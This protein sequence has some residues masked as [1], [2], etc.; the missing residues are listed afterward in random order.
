MK[1][2]IIGVIVIVVLAAAGS[3][4]L[5]GMKMEQQF[6]DQVAMLKKKAGPHAGVAFH[7][8]RFDR[9]YLSSTAVTSMTIDIPAGKVQPG[10]PQQLKFTIQHD[11]Q[12]GPVILNS[13]SHFA[14]AKIDST[15]KLN[16]MFAKLAQFYFGKKPVFLVSSTIAY[17]GT[18]SADITIPPYRGPS[19]TGNFTVNWAGMKGHVNG[20]WFDAGARSRLSAPTLEIRAQDGSRFVLNGIRLDGDSSVSAQGMELG[21]A[22]MVADKFMISRPDGGDPG[23]SVTVDKLRF[24]V[25]SG[26]TK[27][28]INFAEELGFDR[29]NA[30]GKEFENGVVRFEVKNLNRVAL[31]KAQAQVESLSGGMTPGGVDPVALRNAYMLAWQSVLPDLIKSSP[32][33]LISKAGVKFEDGQVSG[34]FRVAISDGDQF[35]MRMGLP[36][37][38]PLVKVELDLDAPVAT[39]TRLA[40][41]VIRQRIGA[42]KVSETQGMTDYDIEEQIRNV[43]QQIISNGVQENVLRLDESGLH[44]KMRFMNGHFYINDRIADELVGRLMS[45]RTKGSR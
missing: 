16:P 3:P 10:M 7:V 24:S 19:H 5:V 37:L 21:K 13:P 34:R 17:D 40:Q 26:Q 12:H 44:S 35:D 8:D 27:E 38:M 4:Y 11:I 23:K 18:S 45:Q 1:K 2:L 36:A 14:L 33:I 41:N 9:G 42:Q 32:E 29:L 39:V 28:L 30:A 31:E 15:L 20:G 25:D 22:T 43:A 6:R